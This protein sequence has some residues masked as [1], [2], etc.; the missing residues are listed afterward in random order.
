MLL[1]DC[2]EQPLAGPQGVP[3]PHHA[4]SG[5][6]N[7]TIEFIMPGILLRIILVCCCCWLLI[8]SAGRPASAASIE[9]NV[10][11]DGQAIRITGL[12][13]L[14]APGTVG[15]DLRLLPTD[16]NHP[17]EAITQWQE[18]M[19]PAAH[20]A[21][22][23][24]QLD[25]TLDL[26]T[27]RNDTIDLRFRCYDVEELTDVV[28]Q[29]HLSAA[30]WWRWWNNAWACC[31]TI[32]DG[33]A[34]TA[35]DMDSLFTRMGLRYTAFVNP[36][37]AMR[38]HR[39]GSPWSRAH[40]DTLRQYWQ[41]GATELG[42]HTYTHASIWN[43]LPRPGGNAG[44]LISAA[45]TVA[46]NWPEVREAYVGS[47]KTGRLTEYFHPGAWDQPGYW[48]DDDADLIVRTSMTTGEHFFAEIERDSV[49]SIVGIPLTAVGTIAYPSYC[50]NRQILEL[51][52]AEGFV[53][54]RGSVDN[55]GNPWGD[56][57]EPPYNEWGRISVFRVP[58]WFKLSSLVGDH[59]LDEA[60]FKA[61]VGDHIV[62]T[63]VL[64]H[65]GV[66]TLITHATNETNAA[67]Y[68]GNYISPQEVQWLCE[69]VA[70]HGG[71]VVPFGEA[72]AYY[73]SLTAEACITPVGDRVYLL[74]GYDV[75]GS[76]HYQPP[77]NPVGVS[78]DPDPV[79]PVTVRMKVYPNPFNPATLV[80]VEIPS[81]GQLV[82][83][84][85]DLRGR[86]VRTL[87]RG[88]VHAGRQHLRWDGCDDGGRS[89]A[90]GI[91]ACRAVHAAGH[92]TVTMTL[93]R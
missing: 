57:T 9:S 41:R 58:V 56:I 36:G 23:V 52:E 83:D 69:A 54:G 70:D 11:A 17:T 32:D 90:A 28:E 62:A 25:L 60:T 18:I 43:L 75:D 44:G 35:S 31:F 37:L 45:D 87:H 86:H 7:L 29:R 66:Y 47:L 10:A 91:Y 27:A 88:E 20:E 50:H 14:P 84:L 72:M 30:P 76:I 63:Q 2:P 19:S 71:I 16:G 46:S 89:V 4:W 38:L 79:V 64:Q 49:T 59:D 53:G 40:P 13:E 3:D 61:G 82:V 26:F 67:F 80:E 5:R 21:A 24:H 92:A 48:Y 34:L 1:L 74:E 6:G 15:I 8:A 85:Y 39:P 51:V 93:V 12:V 22:L 55:G 42:Q 73:R 78:I 81:A 77:A 68:G 65:G 33:M